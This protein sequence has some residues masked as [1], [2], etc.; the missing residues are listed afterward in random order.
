MRHTASAMLQSS[1]WLIAGVLL[2]TAVLL[3]DT[4]LAQYKSP[5]G[6]A[7]MPHVTFVRGQLPFVAYGMAGITVV[8]IGALAMFGKFRWAWLFAVI[9]ALALVVAEANLT[10]LAGTEVQAGDFTQ[11]IQKTVG[12]NNLAGKSTI[13]ISATA[14]R[15]KNIL[16]AVA[17]MGAMGLGM[18]AFFGKFRWTWFFAICGGLLV[19][20][21]YIATAG[22][23]SSGSDPLPGSLALDQQTLL[24]GDGTGGEDLFGNSNTLATNT[25]NKT[26]QIAYAVGAMGIMALAVLA[27]LGRFQWRWFFAIVGG[28]MTMAGLNEGLQYITG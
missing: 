24:I 10:P 18:L 22:Y 28:L 13:L 26:L 1:L 6:N 2:T 15:T 23:L 19:M 25:T 16:Y 8:G 17:A 20:T 7:V 12:N 21:G 14:E 4:A 11:Q 3:P 9:G 27:M 5:L